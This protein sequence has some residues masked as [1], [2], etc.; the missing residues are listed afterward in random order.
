MYNLKAMKGKQ[1]MGRKICFF[2][3]DGTVTDERGGA[4][5]TIP[6][7]TKE[8]L[9]KAHD[10]GVLLF[11]NTGRPLSTVHPAIKNLPWTGYVCGCG[12]W[13]MMEG[14]ELFRHEI[15]KN[16]RIQLMHHIQSLN[17][18][19]VYEAKEGFAVIDPLKHVQMNKIVST[20]LKDGF[21]LLEVNDELVFEKFCFFK[22]SSVPWPD[23]SFLDEYDKIFKPDFCEIVPL[24]CSKGKA[25]AYLMDVLGIDEKDS[26]SFGDSVNDVEMLKATYHSVVMDNAPEDVKKLATYVTDR[27]S[28]DGLY[29]AMEALGLFR[30]EEDDDKK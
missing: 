28:N 26:Y 13:I 10:A 7:S 2:D 9:Q 22:D 16:E 6:E 8:A 4:E 29:K 30:N 11:V 18:S 1:K 12:T 23:L 21:S 3:V 17:L 24:A 14:K 25:C 15:E 5:I 19:C 27:A 20:Y